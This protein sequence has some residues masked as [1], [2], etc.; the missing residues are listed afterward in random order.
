MKYMYQHGK[1]SLA[2]LLALNFSLIYL[3]DR[4][5][6]TVG[7]YENNGDPLTGIPG[8]GVGVYEALQ[9]WVCFSS[10]AYLLFK[11]GIMQTFWWQQEK[12]NGPIINVMKKRYNS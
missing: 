4:Y 7:F 12:I 1:L 2:L 8:S 10:A 5:V 11:I 3:T 9:K 6:L